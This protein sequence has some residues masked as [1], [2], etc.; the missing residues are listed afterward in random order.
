M[1][2]GKEVL[3]GTKERRRQSINKTEKAE[4]L[5]RPSLSLMLDVKKAPL[6][7]FNCFVS[8]LSVL[9]NVCEQGPLPSTAGAGT[10]PVAAAVCCL[11]NRCREAAPNPALEIPKTMMET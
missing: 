1:P 9:I 3:S 10:V 4:I 7:C 11:G 6:K 5:P 2:E 8:F